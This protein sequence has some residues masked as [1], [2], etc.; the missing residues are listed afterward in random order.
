MTCLTKLLNPLARTARS[1]LLITRREDILRDDPRHICCSQSL[2]HA[3]GAESFEE[4][5][6]HY[7]FSR[8]ATLF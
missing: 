1:V 4:L 3:I 7:D 8:K 6:D 2:L 5:P